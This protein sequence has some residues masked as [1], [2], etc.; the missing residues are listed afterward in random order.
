[1]CRIVNPAR[2]RMIKLQSKL[3]K[4]LWRIENMNVLRKTDIPHTSGIRENYEII[5]R[6]ISSVGSVPENITIH[7]RRLCVAEPITESILF[8]E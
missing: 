8:T 7:R 4:R 3:R 2:E 1:M 5:N 6:L